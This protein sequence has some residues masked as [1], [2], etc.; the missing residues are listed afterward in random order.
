[1]ASTEQPNFGRRRPPLAARIGA[2]HVPP[3]ASTPP[4]SPPRSSAP[5]VVLPEDSYSDTEDKCVATDA[6]YV[7]PTS[8]PPY[9]FSDS[10]SADELSDVAN[11]LCLITCEDGPP[12]A[13]GACSVVHGD[14][15]A[16]CSLQSV[17][18][19]ISLTMHGRHFRTPIC[20]ACGER[21][22]LSM[23]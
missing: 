6:A 2:M 11:S 20:L 10:C 7:N 14:A 18:C 9:S 5:A 1:M 19:H 3:G 17:I 22:F 16:V 15:K 13:M 12:E 8:H 21:T 23:A 4:R